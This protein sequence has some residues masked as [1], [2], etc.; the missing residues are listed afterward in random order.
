MKA[1]RFLLL[2]LLSAAASFAASAQY[3]EIANQVS[4]I[5][6]PALSGSLTYRGFAEL[7]GTAGIGA[8]RA[9]I[10]GISTS[11]GFQYASWFFMGAGIGV[12]IAMTAPG[13]HRPA[14]ATEATPDFM[15][16]P[17]AR[18]MAM[19]PVFSD[20]RFTIG[21]GGGAACFIDVKAGATWL[22]GNDYLEFTNAR[23]G[24]GAQFY[25][26]PSIGVR[27]PLSAAGARQAVS[28]GVAYQL[29]TSDNWYTYY[30]NSVTLNGF[31]ATV[32]F[33]W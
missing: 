26:R 14:A 24:G 18:T 15:R 13:E 8:N 22:I 21:A 23:M 17:S 28:I 10:I 25:L 32:A 3:Y 31:G 5:I 6:R 27:V 2:P 7:S 9:N 11:Q 20:F 16:H 12:D 30:D 29:I 4:N 1:F 19:I 33:E